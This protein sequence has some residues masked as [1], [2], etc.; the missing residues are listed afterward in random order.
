M[1]ICR[2]LKH[3]ATILEGPLIFCSKLDRTT[4]KVAK[5]LFSHLAFNARFR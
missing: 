2:V 1:T 5:D 4:V 3:Y